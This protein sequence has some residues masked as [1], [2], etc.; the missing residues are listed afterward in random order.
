PK[1]LDFAPTR[2]SSNE[3]AR[4]VGP[5]ALRAEV[6][7]HPQGTESRNEA[8]RTVVGNPREEGDFRRRQEASRQ[9]RLKATHLISTKHYRQHSDASAPEHR[10][11]LS[12][13]FR[14]GCIHSPTAFRVEN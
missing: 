4:Q 8:G 9:R 11:P 7:R 14:C 12:V 5:S 6:A 2:N 1:M 3:N 10:R 13:Y